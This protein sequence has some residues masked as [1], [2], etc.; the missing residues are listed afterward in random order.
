MMDINITEHD[1]EAIEN[2]VN[3]LSGYLRPAIEEEQT[4]DIFDNDALDIFMKSLII[5][6][7]DIRTEGNISKYTDTK[8]NLSFDVLSD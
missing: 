1:K 7:N 8:G 4:E 3:D 2:I 5:M 6:L